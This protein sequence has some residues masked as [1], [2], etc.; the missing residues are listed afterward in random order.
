MRNGIKF[1][2]SFLTALLFAVGI[3]SAFG[4]TAG[5]GTFVASTLIKIPAGSLGMAVTPEIWTDFIVGNLFKNN[6]F[7]LE[8][9]DESQYVLMGKVVHVPQA[10]SPSGVKR[11][12][13][14]LPATITRRTDV[15]VTYA[16]DEFTTDPRFIPDADKVELSYDKMASCMSEDMSYLRQVLADTMLYNWRPRYFIKATKEKNAKYLI[17]GTGVRTGVCVDDFVKAKAIFNKW[18]TPKEDRFVLLPTEMYNQICDDVRNNG[19]DNL[20]AAV[21]DP[22]TGRLEKL[23]G[24]VIIERQTALLASNSSLSAVT[25]QKYFKFTSDNDLTYT[26]EDYEAIELG[27]KGAANTACAVGLFWQKNFVRRALGETKMFENTGDP[28][29]Y[30]DIYSFLNRM[31]GRKSRGDAKGVLGLIQEY[32]AS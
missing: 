5:V 3:G 20:L 24:F 1:I 19:N 9:I 13:T 26:P 21:Y 11:N 30:G 28:T 32:S 8:S 12:R 7:L 22:K 2:T 15:D 14:Q 6:E 18:G 23:E 4:A 10:G 27:E 31:G 16:L 29:Y 25:G 17:H